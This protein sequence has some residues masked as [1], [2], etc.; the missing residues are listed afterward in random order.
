MVFYKLGNPRRRCGHWYE[1]CLWKNGKVRLRTPSARRVYKNAWSRSRLAI[2]P[3]F[4]H[5]SDRFDFTISEAD[6]E[7]ACTYYT[8]GLTHRSSRESFRLTGCDNEGAQ[9]RDVRSRV[10]SGAGLVRHSSSL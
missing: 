3:L 5:P 9:V 4:R 10:Y 1:R 2:G 6:S 7:I 8:C